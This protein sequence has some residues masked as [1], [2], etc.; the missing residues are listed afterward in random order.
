MRFQISRHKSYQIRILPI[1]AHLT[2]IT[3]VGLQLQIMYFERCN[4]LNS[5]WKVSADVIMFR[6]ICVITLLML[7]QTASILAERL[8]QHHQFIWPCIQ[9]LKPFLALIRGRKMEKEMAPHSITLAWKIPW[10]EEPGRLQS[11]G[12]QR[13][14][15]DWE[16]SL[17]RFTFMHWRRKWQP[18]PV[19]LPGESQGRG[20]LV[21]CH[22][23]G[24]TESDRTEVT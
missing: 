8:L 24:R 15:H 19:F 1:W 13:V 17:S 14:R 10:T 16:T 9:M 6:S 4:W 18:T 7:F 22:L 23:W 11:M 5:N 3:L 12:S 21:G 20:S 2:L